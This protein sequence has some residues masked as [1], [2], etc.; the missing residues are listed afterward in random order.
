MANKHKLGRIQKE[1]ICGI[2]AGLTFQFTRSAGQNVRLISKLVAQWEDEERRSLDRAIASLYETRLVAER[3]NEDGSYTLILS[4][5]GSE[6]ALTSNLENME[7]ERPMQW[8]EK[9]RVVLADIPEKRKGVRDALRSHL[10]QLQFVEFQKSVWVHAYDCQTQIDFLI[11]FYNIR[12]YV[13]F[14]VMGELDNDLHLRKQF[15]L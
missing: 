12:R 7:I 6:Y 14:G 1:I 11:E 4:K 13:R 10:K 2:Y 3:V 15:D 5:E 8:D 9:W